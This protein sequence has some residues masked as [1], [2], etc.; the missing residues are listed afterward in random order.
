MRIIIG[1]NFSTCTIIVNGRGFIYLL[2]TERIGGFQVKE[3]L[4]GAL[5]DGE[6]HIV[7]I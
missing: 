4:D 2:H 3:R 1:V 7:R 5:A 6:H